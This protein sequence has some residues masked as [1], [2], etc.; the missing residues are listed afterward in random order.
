[1]E[2]LEDKITKASKSA[3]A[4]FKRKKIRSIKR[5]AD[6]IAEK[7]RKSELSLKS[8]EPRI[9]NDP[10]SGTPLKKHPPSRNKCIE[11]KIAELNKKIR[12][13][14]NRRNKERLIA[15]R[16]SLRLELNWGPRQLEGAFGGA[17]R[18]YQ[19]DGI[20]G[21]DVDTFFARTKR[22]LID[23]L[24]R[25]TINRAVH[26][27][28]TTWIRI[29]KDGIESVELAFNSRMLAVYNLS[30]MGEIA[31][32]MIEHMQQQI[33][34]PALRDSKFAFDGVIWM[35]IDFHRLNLTRGSSYIG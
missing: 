15:K 14:K 13:A 19:I 20:K 16:D 32:E 29:V 9:F 33:E 4:R 6:K 12:R 11:A 17:Y 24:S 27:Q 35:D 21:M 8:L 28:A 34:N 7:P 1:M 26:S 31:S 5:E 23:L 22:F 25:E 2:E 30:D 10:I 18:H 3:N